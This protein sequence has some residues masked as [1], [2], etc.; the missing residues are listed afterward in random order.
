MRWSKCL[1]QIW[2]PF[3]YKLFWSAKTSL[4]KKY[5]LCTSQRRSNDVKILDLTSLLK[6]ANAIEETPGNTISVV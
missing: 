4:F 3:S 6:N 2:K 5:L 1:N